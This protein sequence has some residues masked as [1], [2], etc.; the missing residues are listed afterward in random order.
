MRN[1]PKEGVRGPLLERDPAWLAV[2]CGWRDVVR[3]LPRGSEGGHTQL[4]QFEQHFQYFTVY[5]WK[6]TYVKQ[7]HLI[8][9][10][11]VVTK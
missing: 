7:T 5:V 4:R 2:R 6:N 3:R 11:N 1:A 8:Y 10:E 9:T